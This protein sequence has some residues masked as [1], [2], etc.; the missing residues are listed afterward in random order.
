MAV[1]VGLAPIISE[2]G[3]SGQ[4]FPDLRFAASEND[5]RLNPNEKSG[6]EAASFDRS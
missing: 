4:S 3:I 2:G 5:G 6:R 1:M